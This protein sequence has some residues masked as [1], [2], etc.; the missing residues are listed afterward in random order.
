MKIGPLGSSSSLNLNSIDPLGW[1]HT[2][3]GPKY[4]DSAGNSNLGACQPHRRHWTAGL[5]LSRSDSKQGDRDIDR[6]VEENKDNKE[7]DKKFWAQ[8]ERVVLCHNN[9]QRQIKRTSARSLT[10]RSSGPRPSR[11]RVSIHY[12]TYKHA[13]GRLDSQAT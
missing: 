7:R 1:P 2:R 4:D 6:T 5:D 13:L 10:L 12:L 8:D 9:D 3:A 11:Q